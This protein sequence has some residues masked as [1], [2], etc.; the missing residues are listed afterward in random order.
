MTLNV[1]E[2]ISKKI[3]RQQSYST[4]STVSTGVGD[5]F[6]AGIL[7]RYVTGQLGQLS[8]AFLHSR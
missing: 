7:F 3:S 6:P 4:S 8:L 1:A 2:M 5:R